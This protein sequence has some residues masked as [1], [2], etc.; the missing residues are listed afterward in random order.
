MLVVVGLLAWG[1]VVE[2]GMDGWREG[3]RER[4]GGVHWEERNTFLGPIRGKR[5]KE[6]I[7]EEMHRER[8]REG[9]RGNER[10]Y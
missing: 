5:E 6:C 1:W 10:H 9:E 8:E 2:G 3:G 4:L 7:H